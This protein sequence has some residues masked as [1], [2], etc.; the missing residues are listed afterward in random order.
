MYGLD[1]AALD[2]WITGNW[3][4]D[5]LTPCN[6]CEEYDDCEYEFN[7]YTCEEERKAMAAEARWELENDRQKSNLADDQ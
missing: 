3:G 4:E 2:R 7:H 6:D 5:Q 1:G